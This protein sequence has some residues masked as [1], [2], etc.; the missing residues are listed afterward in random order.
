MDAIRQEIERRVELRRRLSVCSQKQEICKELCT[1]DILYW[2]DNFAFT[3]R[4]N[5]FLSSEL[6]SRIPMI[7]YPYQREYVKD[8]WDAIMQGSM[9]MSMRRRENGMVVPTNIFSEKSRQMGFSWLLAQIQTYGYIFHNMKSLYLNRNGG[10]VDNGVD[11][12]S[13]FGKIRFIMDCLPWWM[14]P[15]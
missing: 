3:D 11:I 10:E 6:P 2:F 12:G 4:N 5:T 15:K 9:P 14:V 1:R 7:L 8:V 13:H